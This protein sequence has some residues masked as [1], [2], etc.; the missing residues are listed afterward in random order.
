M[1]PD[2]RRAV[3]ADRQA[4]EEIV[5]HAYSPYISRIGRPP[6]PMSDD[7][8][9]LIA[10][11]R[12]YVVEV[13]GTLQGILVLVP[14]PDAMLLDNVAVAPSARGTG[15][16]RSL[17]EY[18]ERSARAAGYRVIRLYTHE[19]MTENI[20]LYARIGYIETHRAEEKGLKR[21]FMVKP[22]V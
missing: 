1:H 16:G 17:L 10:A 3:P 20:A 5:R 2:P 4:I 8:E 15:I 14:E 19:T 9:V 13:E 22:L 21:V 12:V 7:Y 11:G 18:A 6:G